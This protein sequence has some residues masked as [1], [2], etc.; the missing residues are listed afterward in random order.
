MKLM[1]SFLMMF[2]ILDMCF[3]QCPEDSLGGFLG[4]VSP[5][6]WGDGQPAD[7]AVLHDWE[8]ISLPETISTQNIVEKI[9]EF[10]M[11]YEKQFGLDFSQTKRWL[12]SQTNNTVI[13][14]AEDKTSYM[15]KIF[16]YTN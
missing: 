12:I 1:Q 8:Q 16:N 11:C 13:K 6:L 4:A 15:Y 10:L 5:E 3:D 2:Y 9:C 14:K 7:K